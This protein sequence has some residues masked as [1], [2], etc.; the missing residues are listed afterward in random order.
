[1]SKADR[2]RIRATEDRT[3]RNLWV[4]V[5]LQA[6]E[7]VEN[8]PLHSIDF[9]QAVAFFIG[10]GDWVQNRTAIGDYLDLHRDDLERMGR[11]CINQRRV[12]E[13]LQPLLP[14]QP[15]PVRAR[16]SKAEEQRPEPKAASL[17]LLLSP[18][19][20]QIQPPLSRVNPLFPHGI[21]SPP[22]AHGEAA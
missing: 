14:Q 16:V 22:G 2:D 11:R 15:W 12:S 8:A 1:M 5:V 20:H 21:Y 13:G 19:R 3:Y 10:S 7:D 18:P 4:A 6:K 9:A 17:P